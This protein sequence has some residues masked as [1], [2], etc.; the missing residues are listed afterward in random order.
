MTTISCRMF[1]SAVVLSTACVVPARSEEPP[2]YETHIASILRENCVRCHNAQEMKAELD[3]SGPRGIF[4]GSESG[5]IIELGDPDKSLLFEVLHD[6]L[7]PPEDDRE[8]PLARQEIETIRSWIAAGAPFSGKIDPRELMAAS[9]VNNQDIEPLLLLRCATCHGLRQQ[10]GGL[11]VR[12]KASLLQGGKSGPAIVLGKPQDSLLLKRIHAGE[13]PPNALLIRAGVRPMAS[14]EVAQLS[15]WIELSAPEVEVEPDIASSQPDPLVSDQDRQFWSFQPPRPAAPPVLKESAAAVQRTPIDAF[16]LRKLQEQNLE[17]S[18]AA[19]KRALMRRAYFDLTGLPPDPDEVQAYLADSDPLAY[20]KLIDRLLESPRYGERWG[21]YWLDA[22]GYADSEGKRSADPIRPYAYKYRDYV[23]R[24]FNS[25]KPYDRFLLEQLAGDELEDY[26]NADPITPQIVD[27]LVATGFLRMA[28]DGTGSDVVNTVAERLEVVADEI[29]IFG[30]TVL[31]L[32][33][34]CA[35]CHSHKYD[36]LP[37]RDY[38]RLAAVFKGAFDEHDWLKPSS[39]PGQTKSNMGGRYLEVMTPAEKSQQEERTA[40][41]EADI[42]EQNGKLAELAARIR[43]QHR[44]EE[45]AKLPAV[46]HEDLKKML[47]TPAAERT[48]VQQYLA[49]KFEQ[50]LAL[51]DKQVKAAE[52][53]QRPALAITRTIKQLEGE[54]QS[55]PKI[56]ALWDRG[57]PSPTYIY[58]RGD[59]R[60]QGRLVGPGVPSVLTDGKTPLAV[61]PPWPGALKSGRRLALAKWLVQPDHPLTARV[62]VNRIWRHHFGR[63]IVKSVDNFGA[64]GDRPTHPELLDWLACEFVRQGWSVKAMHRLIMCSAVYRQSSLLTSDRAE[65]DPENAWLSRMPLRRLDAEEVRDSLLE[66]AG[67]L[68]ERPFG[69]PDAVDVRGDGLV[70][71]IGDK[72]SWRRSIYLRQRRREMPSLLET[73]DMPQMNPACQERP[74]STVAQQSLYLMNNG[75]IRGLSQHFAERV[76]QH[77]AD[78]SGQV[79]LAYLT[80]LSRPP[81]ADELSLGT[82]TLLALTEQWRKS[83]PTTGEASLTVE[84]LA[85]AVF[86]HTLMNSAEFLYID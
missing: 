21:R 77:T 25:D 68:E 42:A 70:T 66:V 3:L 6:D 29:D 86:C 64:L 2:R 32:S 62:M 12:T 74:T 59:F 4:A 61:Q 5:P 79:A 73:F 1:L 69:R 37:Q 24:A 22:A 23:I 83:P 46:L 14:D 58:V 8:R 78:P 56:R 9:E 7:M 38:Y 67:K 65:R 80:A 75:A 49:K 51:D 19:D 47:T 82:E 40:A 43:Q 71:S 52:G 48:A 35:R 34:K 39:V 17:L 36:P 45:L 76:A 54:K 53:Y 28:P 57:E 13:M 16:V 26:E 20:E 81:T 44:D 84:Q 31:G 63:G 27:N 10:E 60:Q 11:D 50:T 15:R 85:L 33:M 30:S 72:G 18:P 41:I 55:Q